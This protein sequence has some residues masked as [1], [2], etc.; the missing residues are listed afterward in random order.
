MMFR[1]FQ[2]SPNYDSDNY[3]QPAL[4]TSLGQLV[5]VRLTVEPR[6]LEELLEALAALDFPV[7]PELIHSQGAVAVEFPA[8]DANVPEVQ[9]MLDRCGFDPE[10]LKLFGVLQNREMAV[11]T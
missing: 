11:L 4:F 10:S 2:A 8:Y 7:N 1:P 6:H 9:A 5:V 3:S